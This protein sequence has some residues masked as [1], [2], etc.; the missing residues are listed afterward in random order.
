MDTNWMARGRCKDMDPALFFPSDSIG[1]RSAQ[2]V[3]VDCTVRLSCLRFALAQRINDGVWGGTSERQR[4][5]LLQHNELAR[6]ILA[7]M[8]RDEC[9]RP[10]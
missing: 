1:V 9:A 2:R 10:F 6:G 4:R 5:R 7:E 8:C 3:C